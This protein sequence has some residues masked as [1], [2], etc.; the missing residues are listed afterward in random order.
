M[1]S[2]EF[3]K[4]CSPYLRQRIVD[5]AKAFSRDKKVQEDLLYVGWLAIDGEYGD[6]VQAHYIDV[7][8][9]SMLKHYKLY[10]MPEPKPFRYSGHD[11]G[12]RRAKRK[13]RFYKKNTARG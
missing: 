9:K 13:L 7:A 11:P 1:N 6:S 3:C 8:H 12:V 4:N 10:Y 2:S 5:L